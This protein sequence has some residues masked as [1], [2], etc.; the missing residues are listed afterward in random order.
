MGVRLGI[1]NTYFDLSCFNSGYVRLDND[2]RLMLII[3]ALKQLQLLPKRQ[4]LF[5]MRYFIQTIFC[6]LYVCV[7]VG[8]GLVYICS[9]IEVCL[10]ETALSGGRGDQP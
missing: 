5:T 8:L 7:C 1:L 10:R 6:L 3:A 2:E 4:I 9:I